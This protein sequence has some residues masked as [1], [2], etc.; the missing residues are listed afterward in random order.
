MSTYTDTQSAT[1]TRYALIGVHDDLPDAIDG[2]RDMYTSW[3]G[4]EHAR[5]ERAD[6]ADWH[7]VEIEAAVR[8][9]VE[10]S[11]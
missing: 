11:P 4:A 3:E 1:V 6:H 8:E 2:Y 9:T 5:R 10:V 7:V